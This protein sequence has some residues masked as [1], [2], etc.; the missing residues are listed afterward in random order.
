MWDHHGTPGG[1]FQAGT[2]D[3]CGPSSWFWEAAAGPLPHVRPREGR[4]CGWERGQRR[5]E[6]DHGGYAR[7][8]GRCWHPGQVLKGH[9]KMQG[10]LLWPHQG[11]EFKPSDLQG[12]RAASEGWCH[13]VPPSA[14]TPQGGL[15]GLGTEHLLRAVPESSKEGSRPVPHPPAPHPFARE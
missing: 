13:L 7:R 1:E 5:D 15:P 3:P 11:K 2:G 12:H 9:P 8:R 4:R 6:R 14:L 10:M